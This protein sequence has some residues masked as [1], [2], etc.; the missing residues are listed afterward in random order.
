VWSAKEI[1]HHINNPELLA[2]FLAIKA[3]GREWRDITVLIWMDNFTAVTYINRKGGT[4]SRQLCQLAIAVWEWCLERNI[5][6]LSEHILGQCNQIA[7]AESRTVRN[8][9]NWMLNPAVFQRIMTQMGPLE[10]DLFAS[11]LAKQLP[12]LYSWRPD[13]RQKPPM[14]S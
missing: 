10:V 4:C 7:D 12:H 2:A 3:L 9:C 6:L 11:R 14:L 8:R 1:L 13:Q 5:T